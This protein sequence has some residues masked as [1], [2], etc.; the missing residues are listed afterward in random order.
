M[1][2]AQR[3][4]LI[5]MISV[6]LILPAPLLADLGGKETFTTADVTEASANLDCLDYCIVGVC[7]WLVCSLFEC[8]VETSPRIRHRLP[9]VVVQAYPH[10]GKMPW[11]EGESLLGNILEQSVK[12]QLG[13]WARSPLVGGG[14]DTLNEDREKPAKKR[15]NNLWF[16]EASVIGNPAVYAVSKLMQNMDNNFLC[17]SEVDAW[18]PYFQSEFDAIVWRTVASELLYPETWLPGSREI[19]HWPKSTWGPVHPRH[20]FLLQNAEPKVGAVMAQRAIDVATRA[21]QPHVYQRVPGIDESNEKTDQW[22]MLTPKPSQQCETF[23]ED[24]DWAVNKSDKQGRYS[25]LYWALHE[26]CVNHIGLY[27]GWI[28]TGE[29][30]F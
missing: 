10:P 11:V 25:W 22:Q 13:G 1:K 28:P 29:I 26:C 23:G 6:A 16:K 27:I 9:D 18:R 8:H 7:L 15:S 14:N 17:P 12:T 30:C 2:L 20:G 24:D 21:N 3:T 5:L 19:G 4:V